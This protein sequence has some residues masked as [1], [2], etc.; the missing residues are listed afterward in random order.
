MQET[1]V[2]SQDL[3]D[4]L[5]KEMATYSSI[6]AL[7]LPWIEEAGGLVSTGSQRVGPDLATEQQQQVGEKVL[8]RWVHF[9][10]RKFQL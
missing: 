4:P 5:E 1:I 10:A 3:E 2:W 8:R 9:Q 7:E 6:L